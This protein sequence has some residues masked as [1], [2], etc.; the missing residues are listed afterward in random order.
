[1]MRVREKKTIV[2]RREDNSIGGNARE[3][4]G[5]VLQRELLIK[6]HLGML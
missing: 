4:G 5:S 3:C 1:M 6:G 2:E